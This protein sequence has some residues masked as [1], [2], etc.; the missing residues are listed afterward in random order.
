MSSANVEVQAYEES[1]GVKSSTR[2]IWLS[3]AGVVLLCTIAMTVAIITKRVPDV[4]SGLGFLLSAIL[5]IAGGTKVIQNKT[6]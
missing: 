5:G 1:P 3:A 6:E 2:I 4:P